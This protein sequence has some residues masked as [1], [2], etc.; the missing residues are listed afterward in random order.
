MPAQEN[1]QVQPQ[2]VEAAAP[3][4]FPL[5]SVAELVVVAT[6][7]SFLVQ[8]LEALQEPL[9]EHELAKGAVATVV[10]VRGIDVPVPL[11]DL[12]EWPPDDIRRLAQKAV[13]DQLCAALHQIDETMNP[14]REALG[15][16]TELRIAN[17]LNVM[18]P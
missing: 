17:Q 6:Q 15:R 8:N 7:L 11:T 16:Y 3:N 1:E 9:N 18:G 14:I 12:T 13:F 2:A 5:Q 10:Y 4:P